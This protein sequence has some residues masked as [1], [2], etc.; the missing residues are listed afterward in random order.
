M[1]CIELR[2]SLMDF[3]LEKQKG[4]GKI[5]WM[6]KR[7]GGVV[8]SLMGGRQFVSAD[9]AVLPCSSGS[10]AFSKLL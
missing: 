5:C 10:Q 7:G 3:Y 6:L 1:C 8:R 9:F 4:K 2:E